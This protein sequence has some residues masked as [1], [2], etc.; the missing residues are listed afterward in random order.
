MT[1]APRRPGYRKYGNRKVIRNG[2]KF[3]SK[4]ESNDWQGHRLE[5]LS[6]KYSK[7]HRQVHIPLIVNGHLVCTYVADHVMVERTIDG[8][9]LVIKDTKSTITADERTYRLKVKLLKALHGVDVSE[10]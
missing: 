6:G 2:V 8:G 5:Q 10:I 7:L 4:K 3:D 9:R 1:R